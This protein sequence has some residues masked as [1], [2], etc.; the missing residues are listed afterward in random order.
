MFIQYIIIV[1]GISFLGLIVVLSLKHFEVVR[2]K[3]ILPLGL[4][5]KLD[6]YCRSFNQ[7]VFSVYKKI[8]DHLIVFLSRIPRNF[9]KYLAIFWV[10]LETKILHPLISKFKNYVNMVRGRRDVKIGKTISTFLGAVAHYK[11]HIKKN[12][13]RKNEAEIMASEDILDTTVAENSK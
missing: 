2:G 6:I 9:L 12:K 10:L 1:C 3:N 13:E 5:D 4:R 7:K 11:R 8:A